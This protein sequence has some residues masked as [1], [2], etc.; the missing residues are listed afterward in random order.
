VKK[1]TLTEWAAAG[2]IIGTIAVVISLLFVGYSINRNTDATQ[3]SSENILF[4]RHT[5]LA[6]QFMTDPTFAEILIKKR[7]GEEI[8][9]EIEAVR[10]EKYELNMLDLWALAH[11]RFQR[12]LLSEEQWLTWDRYFTHMFSNEAEAISKNRWL[13][14]QYGFD[15]RFWEHVG[16]VL[17]GDLLDGQ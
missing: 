16:D 13:E 8:L 3:A 10:W 7:T 12:D 5:N 9:S 1:L 6:N 11:S 4:E 15:T 17:F 2:E 14:L